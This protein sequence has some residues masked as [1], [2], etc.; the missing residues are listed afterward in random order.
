MVVTQESNK[1]KEKVRR[2]HDK[3]SPKKHKKAKVCSTKEKEVKQG[4]QL[5]VTQEAD[6]AKEKVKKPR[7][8]NAPK[9]QKKA[10]V[11][12]TQENREDVKKNNPQADSKTV[13]LCRH[14]FQALPLSLKEKCFRV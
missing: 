8:K 3:N 5:V 11:F 6:K 13:C 12:F 10:Q 1:G 4:T 2:P 14:L 9:K 7:D